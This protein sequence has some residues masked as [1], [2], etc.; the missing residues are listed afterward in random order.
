MF[1]LVPDFQKKHYMEANSPQEC[2]GIN[3]L[4]FN[5]FQIC[6][7]VYAPTYLDWFMNRADKLK[8]MQFHKRFLQ[9]MQSGGV[10]SERWLLKTPVHM[11]RLKE[12]F[13]VYP[14][15]K[16]IMTHRHPAKIVASA[17][18]LI[19]SVRSLYSNHEDVNRSGREQCK[20]W[21]D[22]FDRFLKDRQQLDKEDQIIDL[23]FEDFVGDQMGTV[24]K[25]YQQFNWQLT[26]ASKLNMENFLAANPKDKHGVHNYS[27]EQ[28]GLTNEIINQAYKDYIRVL[29]KIGTV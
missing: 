28:I 9:Y 20:M 12:L 4:D 1:K 17:T 23:K 13:E 10:K 27:L 22:C 21:S 2:I 26:E 7:Q 25:I 29:E 6:A 8:T 19:S 3:M 15:A 18:S 16:I 24:K 5:S 11:L 14:D